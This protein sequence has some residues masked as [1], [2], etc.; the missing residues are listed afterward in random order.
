MLTVDSPASLPGLAGS[1]LGT[2]DWLRIGQ[3]R[4]DAFAEV[5]EDR[6]WIHVDPERAAA[7]P[8]GGPIAHG[9]LSLSLIS[10]FFDQLVEL[11]G[12]D[13]LVNYGLNK[14]RFPTPVLVGSRVRGSGRLAEVRPLG[15]GYQAVLDLVVELEGSTKPACVAAF[16]VRVL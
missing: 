1:S 6:Q 10:H 12:A 7:S 15:R 8:F 5:T 16:V 9:F 2:T 14:V 4:V 3:D 13:M 11:R